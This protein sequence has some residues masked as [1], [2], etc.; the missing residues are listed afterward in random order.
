MIE[1]K[2]TGGRSLLVVAIIVIILASAFF[3]YALNSSQ[4]SSPQSTSIQNLQKVIVALQSRNSELESRIASGNSSPQN[5]SL[6][7]GDLVR[8]YD[9]V[10]RSVVT[11]QGSVV[12]T[13]NTVFGPQSSVST[14]IGSGFIVNYLGS[15][16]VATNFHVINGVVNATVTFWN[17]D[18]FPATVVGSDPYSD[19]AVVSVKA[20][21]S[22]LYPLQVV[23]STSLK[24]GQ[25]V[26]AIGN[27]F[28]LSSSM[29]YG[30]VSQ[31][32]RTIQE[33]AAGQFPISD[34]IQFSAPINPGNS[35]G[36]LL[37]T[38]G[39]VIGITTAVV[40]GSQGVGFAIPSNAI[41][42][43]LPSLI[44]TGKYEM[45]PYL[46]IGG[47]DMNYELS[48]IIGTN[49]TYG[50][51]VQNVVPGGPADKAGIKAGAK[52][53]KVQGQQYSVGG[54]IIVSIN[55]T[56]IVNQDALSTYL[57]GRVIAGQAVEVGVVRSGSVTTIQVVLGVRPAPS[58][59]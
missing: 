57:Q 33:Q 25:L 31:L 53:V 41:L 26:V 43:E 29:T 54:D 14:V 49:V 59:G 44:S 5:V 45:H 40:G 11:I 16:Y 13:T 48:Q 46:G 20:P 36:P 17:G 50:V 12:T 23:P 21:A 1:Q 32:G 28:G 4:N 58:Q 55:G 34:V 35:G 10:N 56:R 30:I 37:D 8:I 42:R 38:N 24:V 52:T 19:L 39:R 9:S 15:W 47:A 18:A 51:L 3:I 6:T 22:E 27:P 7:G 2:R